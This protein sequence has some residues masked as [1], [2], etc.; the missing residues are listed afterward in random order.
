[1]KVHRQL[2]GLEALAL[3]C[4]MARGL[5]L[6]PAGAGLAGAGADARLAPAE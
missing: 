2:S 3:G 5:A 1:M 6:R 4:T